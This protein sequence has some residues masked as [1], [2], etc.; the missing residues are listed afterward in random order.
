MSRI[1]I[2]QEA[3]PLREILEDPKKYVDTLEDLEKDVGNPEDSLG[4]S[5]SHVSLKEGKIC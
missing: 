4:I 2:I 5:Y 3:D 1:S